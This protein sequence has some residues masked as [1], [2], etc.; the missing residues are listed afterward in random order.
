MP[1]ACT[2]RDFLPRACSGARFE[3]CRQPCSSNGTGVET[4]GQG[5]HLGAGEAAHDNGSEDEDEG[6]LKAA[7][8]NARAQAFMSVLND[9]WMLEGLPL[10]P[11]QK[12]VYTPVS[13]EEYMASFV[14]GSGA[15]ADRGA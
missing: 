3:T 13:A 7:K 6:L 2:Q 12:L 15:S 4:S 9:P 10:E 1:L 14:F 11:G 8:E 5:G